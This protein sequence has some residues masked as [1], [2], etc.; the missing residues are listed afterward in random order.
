MPIVQNN[1]EVKGVK[2][3][4]S[5]DGDYLAPC[6]IPCLFCMK[7]LGTKPCPGCLSNKPGISER[8]KHCRIKECAH[9]KGYARCHEC[10]EFPC[11][12]LKS[13]ER[14]YQRN[15]GVSLCAW[16]REAGAQGVESLMTHLLTV[17]TCAACGELVSL[18]EGLCSGCGRQYPLGRGRNG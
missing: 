14:T 13:L 16:N 11:K 1:R 8:C 5:I 6:G 3:P 18:H 17:Y 7:H 4:Q 2:A 15:Y 9:A 12:W 10:P